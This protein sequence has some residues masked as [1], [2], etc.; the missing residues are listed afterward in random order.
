MEVP[1]AVPTPVRLT[2]VGL[3]I[4]RNSDSEKSSLTVL[5]AAV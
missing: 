5:L 1:E 4:S 3:N 2:L